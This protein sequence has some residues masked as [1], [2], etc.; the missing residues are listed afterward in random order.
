MVVCELWEMPLVFV[1]GVRDAS[2]VYMG[3]CGNEFEGRFRI[4]IIITQASSDTWHSLKGSFSVFFS[5]FPFYG[6]T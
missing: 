5:D 3:Q 6:P 4:I 1:W 2:A